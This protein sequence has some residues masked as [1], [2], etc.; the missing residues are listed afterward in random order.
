M[1]GDAR[2]GVKRRT[3]EA[4]RAIRIAVQS[5]STRYAKQVGLLDGGRWEGKGACRDCGKASCRMEQAGGGADRVTPATVTSV[6][7]LLAT[8]TQQVSRRDCLSC[9]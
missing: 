9:R 8:R 7:K 5:F 3:R 6:L 2:A 4:G 1:A